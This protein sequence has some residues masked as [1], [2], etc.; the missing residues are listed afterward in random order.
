MPYLQPFG[1]LGIERIQH[2]FCGKWKEK[3]KKMML[4]GYAAN[5]TGD[6]YKMFDLIA[7]TM[8]L[9][10]DIK[11]LE[12]KT[13][14][15]YCRMSIF[16][17]RPD[18]DDDPGIDDKEYH[19][20]PPPAPN[21]ILD[22]DDVVLEAGSKESEQNESALRPASVAVDAVQETQVA[23]M[24]LAKSARLGRE[25]KRLAVSFNPEAQ[26]TMNTVVVEGESGEEI[27]EQ[28]HFC[29]DAIYLGMTIKDDTEYEVPTGILDILNGKKNNKWTPSAASKVMNFISRNCWEKV[30]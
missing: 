2:K 21:I 16:N 18:L 8:R 5:H 7:K 9:S 25:L 10:Q 22:E 1:R 26:E 19:P 6:T 12:W 29:F 20:V 28:I 27:V 24:A 14:D 23:V 13:P 3:G 11:W 17:H 4:I 30:P 15:H